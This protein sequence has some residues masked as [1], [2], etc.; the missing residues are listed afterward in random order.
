VY[1]QQTEYHAARAHGYESQC[2]KRPCWSV[3]QPLDSMDQVKKTCYYYATE[4]GET[5]G[6]EG[7]WYEEIDEGIGLLYLVLTRATTLSKTISLSDGIDIPLPLK[8]KNSITA[9][10][11]APGIRSTSAEE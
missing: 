3:S 1:K 2:A 7:N 5:P 9:N 8:K 4:K 11:W 6:K 10:G